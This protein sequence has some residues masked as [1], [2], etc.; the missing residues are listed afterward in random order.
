M[1]GPPV[2]GHEGG[3]ALAAAKARVDAGKIQFLLLFFLF[4]FRS[5]IPV[6]LVHSIFYHL[7]TVFATSSTSEGPSSSGSRYAGGLADDEVAVVDI[8]DSD[9]EMAGSDDDAGESDDADFHE[10]EG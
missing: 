1:G 2:G 10:S 7:L 3:P 8:V 6:R 4:D 5:K 9:E